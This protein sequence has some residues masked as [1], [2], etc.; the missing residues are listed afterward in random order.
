MKIVSIISG[1]YE[2]REDIDSPLEWYNVCGVQHGDGEL[3]EHNFYV[4][5][6]YYDTLDEALGD[7]EHFKSGGDPIY[8]NEES[9]E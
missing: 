3:G 6:V 7:I 4:E 5:E 8:L 2:T 9:E 1:P